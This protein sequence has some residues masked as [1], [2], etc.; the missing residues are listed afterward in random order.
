MDKNKKIILIPVILVILA[1]IFLGYYLG[2]RGKESSPNQ[3]K[4]T[5]AAFSRELEPGNV[6]EE[7]QAPASF[8]SVILDISGTV[9]KIESD[10]VIL[11]GTGANFADGKPRELA[12]VMTSSSVVVMPSEEYKTISY[13]GKKGL[14]Y[15]KVGMEA[16]VHSEENLRGKTEF[17]ASKITVLQ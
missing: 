7:S 3:P 8:P 10:R 11:K 6:G 9:S 16:A 13:L 2:R 12:V 17:K 1:L 4:E 15:L 5:E 14:E